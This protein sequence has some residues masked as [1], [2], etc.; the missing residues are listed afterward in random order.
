MKGSFTVE[1]AFIIPIVTAM[2]LFV[3]FAVLWLYDRDVARMNVSDTA[4]HAA[5]LAELKESRKVTGGTDKEESSLAGRS[6]QYLLDA[7]AAEDLETGTYKVSAFVR[8]SANVPFSKWFNS[9]GWPQYGSIDAD[10]EKTVLYH[11][12]FIRTYRLAKKVIKEA[13]K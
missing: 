5:E 1:A 12:D 7:S 13:A 8:G 11:C 6:L 4:H 2:M 9:L 10:Y 3:G